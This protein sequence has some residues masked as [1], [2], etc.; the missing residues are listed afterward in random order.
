MHSETQFKHIKIW[1]LPSFSNPNY[2]I[3]TINIYA[4]L[5]HFEDFQLVSG[6]KYVGKH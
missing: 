1:I 2:A 6:R 4:I 5:R 3:S